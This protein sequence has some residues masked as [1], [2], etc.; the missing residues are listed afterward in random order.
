MIRTIIVEDEPNALKS[1]VLGIG[2]YVPEIKI[3][4]EASDVNTAKNI[5]EDTLPELVLLDIKLKESDAFQLLDGLSNIDFE[6]IF[7]TAYG[8]YKEKAFDYFALNYLQKPIDFEKMNQIIQAYIKRKT[9]IFNMEKYANLRQLLESG[10][11]VLSIPS[12]NGYDMVNIDDIV[13]C[14][15][16]G[17]YTEIHV[18]QGTPLMASKSLKHYESLLNGLGF[19]RIHRSILLNVKYIQSVHESIIMLTNKQTLQISKRNKKGLT[20]LMRSLS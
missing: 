16:E 6:I 12:R 13:W 11:K 8:E 15:A 9:R 3:I 14:R 5:I 17:N 20:M 2:K 10:F 7:I 1:L 18:S 19:F 4:G